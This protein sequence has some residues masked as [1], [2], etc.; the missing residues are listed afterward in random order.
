MSRNPAVGVVV[1]TTLRPI[2]PNFGHPVCVAFP[3]FDPAPLV[4]LELPLGGLDG[5]G[6]VALGELSSVTVGVERGLMFRGL[7]FEGAL[8]V[9]P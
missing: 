8:R 4:V 6:H 7:S 2:F 9:W 1:G 5:T 3:G